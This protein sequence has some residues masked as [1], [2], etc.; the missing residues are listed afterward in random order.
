[1][2]DGV[3]GLMAQYAH[4]PFV[5]AALDFEHLRFLEP[6]EPRMREIERDGDRRTAV[7]GEPF[8]GEIEVQR[9]SKTASVELGPQLI[10][11]R[12]QGAAKRQAE[13]RQTNVE[14]LLVSQFWPVVT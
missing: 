9:E 4:A 2:I 5:L 12:R 1:M 13:I 3:H 7:R 11:A 14:E 8:V 6:L 10:D